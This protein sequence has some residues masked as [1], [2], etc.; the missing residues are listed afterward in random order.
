MPIP[1]TASTPVCRV[2]L[3]PA[4][5]AHVPQAPRIERRVILARDEANPWQMRG[6]LGVDATGRAVGVSNHTWSHVDAPYHR[7]ASGATLDR[8]APA[9][10]LASRTRVVDLTASDA[11]ARRERI[12]GVEYHSLIDADDVPAGL[13]GFEA[14]LFVTGFGPL[15]E[16]GYPMAEGADEHYPSL[17]RAAAERLAAVSSLRLVAMDSPT[18]D[19]PPADGIA[20]V[21]LLGRA[22]TPVLLVETLTCERLRR[23]A[24]PL[25]REGVLTVEPLRAFG[26]DPDGA[27]ASVFFYFA[28]EGQDAAAFETFSSVLRAATL[29]SCG[30]TL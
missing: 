30:V 19:K 21:T 5:Y 20:H 3:S 9:H 6:V 23:A 18:V 13:D 16:Q 11:P 25:P 10:Y 4:E 26:P 1:T 14:V 29:A 15:I 27:L 17:T 2:D 28:R 7:L 8:I 24:S 22:P 12:R